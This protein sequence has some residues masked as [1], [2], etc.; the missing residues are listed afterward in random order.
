MKNSTLPIVTLILV[1]AGG[2]YLV[3]IGRLKLPKGASNYPI[4]SSL[5]P[6]PTP[7]LEP[8]ADIDRELNQM[9]QDL[10]KTSPDDFKQDAFIDPK[11][12]Y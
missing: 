3:S 10:N 8:K 4:I 12:S 7:T 6:T 9:D 1:I 2:L 11:I 5:A